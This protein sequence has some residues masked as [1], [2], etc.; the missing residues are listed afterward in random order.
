MTLLSFKFVVVNFTVNFERQHGERGRRMSVVDK[1]NKIDKI[2]NFQPVI[3]RI[4]ETVQ[5][6][7]KVW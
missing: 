1:I 7:T 4:S 5:D 6:K 3:C 2:S